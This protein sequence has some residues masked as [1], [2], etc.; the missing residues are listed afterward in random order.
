[1]FADLFAND[2][3]ELGRTDLVTHRIYTE[4]VPPIKSRPY[5][6]LQSEQ[7]FVKEEIQKMLENNLI[8]TSESPWTS[9]VVLVKKKNR[10]LRFCVD[11][12]NLTK[13]LKRMLTHYHELTRCSIPYQDQNGF[14]P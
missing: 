13:L 5:S 4:D 11:Y 8:C 10:K 9:P 1:E 2:I 6:I 12:R 3:S 14:L 7:I